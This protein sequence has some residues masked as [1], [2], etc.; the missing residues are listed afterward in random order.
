MLSISLLLLLVAFFLALEGGIMNNPR[1]N[2]AAICVVV[3]AVAL[4]TSKLTQ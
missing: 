1:L 2:S 4:T 3:I